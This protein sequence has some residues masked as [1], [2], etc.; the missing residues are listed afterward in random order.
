MPS[1]WAMAQPRWHSMASSIDHASFHSGTD[2]RGASAGTKR[3]TTSVLYAYETLFNPPP[4][5]I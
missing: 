4:D 5:G 1:D 3:Q 2:T